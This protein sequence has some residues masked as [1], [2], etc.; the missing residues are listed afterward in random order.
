MSWLIKQS[1]RMK[2]LIACYSVAAAFSLA[3]LVAALVGGQGILLPLVLIVVLCAAVYPLATL[4][5]RTLSNSMDEMR[6]AAYQIAKG[7]FTIR[8]EGDDDTGASSISQAFNSMVERLRDILRETSAITRLVSDASRN[9][10]ERNQQLKTVMEQVTISAGELATGANQISED[11]SHMSES[12]S[13]IES[14]VASYAD[15]TKQMNERSAHTLELVRQGRQAVENQS[16][17]MRRNV[18]ATE[19]VSRTIEELAR[20]A[21]G[22]SKITRSISEIADQTNLLSLNASIEAA[23]AGEHGRGFAVV[24]QEVRKLAEEA[25]AS[26]KEVFTL[27]RGIEQGIKNAIANMKVNESIVRDQNEL[28][29]QSTEIFNEIVKSVEFI[30]E[31]MEAFTRES[32]IMLESARK[33]AASIQNISAITQQSAAGTEQ[34]SAS[35]NEQ[36]AAVQSVVDEAEQMQQTVLKLQRTIQIFKI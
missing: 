16:E 15:S 2:C 4:F 30:S 5:E 17:G 33:I 36:M 32:D 24:A 8:L 14:K 9:I 18:E 10:Y 21:D 19:A 7:D 12:I 1:I 6:N 23:R 25:G 34:V 22:I 3:M 11:V 26:T 20:H 13:E 28:I 27:V 35:M 31:Q 29:R